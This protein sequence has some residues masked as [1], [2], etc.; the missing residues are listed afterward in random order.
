M[1]LWLAA[2]QAMAQQDQVLPSSDVLVINRQRLF[3]ES[4]YGRAI[5]FTLNQRAGEIRA[6]NQRLIQDLEAEERDLALKR[7]T[8]P[9]DEFQTLAEAFDEKVQ[10]IRRDRDTQE[11]RFDLIVEQT[12]VDFTNKTAPILEKILLESGASIILYQTEDSNFMALPKVDVTAIAI[13]RI[14]A[15][16][17]A[18]GS[19]P[20]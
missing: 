2:G 15:E 6:E 4:A 12:R 9:Q 16:F 7:S 1:M 20:Q 10:K 19:T 13:Q 17:S 5:L 8:L 14:D 11:R 3:E 18:N